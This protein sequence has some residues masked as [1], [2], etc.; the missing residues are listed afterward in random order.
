MLGCCDDDML[1]KTMGWLVLAKCMDL[2]EYG[3]LAK[4]KSVGLVPS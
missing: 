4:T 2:C 1:C 3:A